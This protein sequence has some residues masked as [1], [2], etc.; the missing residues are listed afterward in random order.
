MLETALALQS[1]KALALV[2]QWGKALE[3][4]VL[5]WGKA[6]PALHKQ[7]RASKEVHKQVPLQWDKELVERA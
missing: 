7:G 6:S 3:A 5:Q 1:G 4:L 2:V